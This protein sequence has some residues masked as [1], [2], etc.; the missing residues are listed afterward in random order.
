[1]GGKEVSLTTGPG[2]TFRQI[3]DEMLVRWPALARELL[4]SKG[5]LRSNIHIFLNGRDVRYL[6]GLEMPIPEDADVCIFPPVGGG[7]TS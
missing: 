1:V 4:D 6:G 3:I 7:R 5:E 2:D